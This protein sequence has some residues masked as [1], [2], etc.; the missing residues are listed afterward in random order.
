MTKIIEIKAKLNVKTGLRIGS[1]DNEIHIGG[2]DAPVIKDSFTKLPYIPG[3]SIKGKIRSLLEL[4]SGKCKGTPLTMKD[5]GNDVFAQ[6]IVKLFGESA[7][8]NN[9]E[10]VLG[11]LSFYDSKLINAAEL[12]QATGN[13]VTEIKSENVIDRFKGTASNPRQIERVI[14]GAKFDF[15]ICLKQFENDNINELLEVLKKG[16]KL[17]EMDSLGGSGSRGYGKI[18]FE[19]LQFDEVIIN[20]SEVNPFPESN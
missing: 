17:L 5:A 9:S 4:T 19:D 6:N 18:E 20:L 2:V 8:K 3:S 14:A 7:N 10:I 16:L 13:Y 15:K 11:K 12:K 1:G